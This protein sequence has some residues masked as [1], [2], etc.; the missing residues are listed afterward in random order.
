M[1]RLILATALLAVVGAASPAAADHT[2]DVPSPAPHWPGGPHEGLAMVSDRSG[3]AFPLAPAIAAW[4]ASHALRVVD[5]GPVCPGGGPHFCITIY[6]DDRPANTGTATTHVFGDH[7]LAADVYIGR[8]TDPSVALPLLTHEIGHAL[9]LAH[10]TG[11]T[12][13]MQGYV[14]PGYVPDAHDYD[15]LFQNRRH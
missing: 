7:I 13:V 11:T 12:S 8:G 4:D 15:M 1:R 9:G 2:L 5:V 10:R 3:G 14:S 6:A